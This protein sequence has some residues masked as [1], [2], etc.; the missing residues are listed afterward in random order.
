MNKLITTLFASI[1]L[2]TAGG[3]LANDHGDRGKGGKHKRGGPQG[4]MIVE[5]FTRE[6][7]KL[8]LSD[9]QKASV[10][11]IMKDLKEQSKPI[12]K[13]QRANQMA[14]KDLIQ[15]DAWDDNTAGELAAIA[16]DLSAQRTLLTS[17]AL[18]D[19]YAQLTDEQRAELAAKAQERQDRR[20]DR[21]GKRAERMAEQNS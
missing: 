12:A 3:A 10:K 20:G 19:I 18:S 9:E 4:S 17:K 15:S 6:L 7:R 2:I 21:A 14:L 16:G 13:D 5:Q 1:F 11:A 8:D